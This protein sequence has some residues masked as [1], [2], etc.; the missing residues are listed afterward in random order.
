MQR[1][2]FPLEACP[3]RHLTRNCIHSVRH[4]FELF[5]PVPRFSSGPFL[6]TSSFIHD[7]EQGLTGP[8]PPQVFEEY[9]QDPL[10][11]ERG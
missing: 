1:A 7:V 6:I 9:L 10:E 2:V 11:I 5:Y 8:I 4:C 3:H